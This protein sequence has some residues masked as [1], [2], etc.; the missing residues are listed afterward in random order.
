MLPAG[1]VSA[2]KALNKPP[3]R[4]RVPEAATPEAAALADEALGAVLEV[5][6]GE[7]V[8]KGA[9]EKLKA[10]AMLREEICGP[11]PKP[12]ELTGKDGGPIVVR[13]VKYTDEGGE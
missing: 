2:I 13:V 4:L 8:V 6:R 12:V 9:G 7:W 5:M 11:Q 3:T 1:A 10:A